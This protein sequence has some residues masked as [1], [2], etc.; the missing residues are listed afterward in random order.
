LL[1]FHD[2]IKADPG[3]FK[4]LRYQD[5][6]ITQ[7]DCPLDS[8]YADLW[9]QHNY[10]VY[11][12]E[13]MKIWHTSQGSYTLHEGDCVLVRKGAFIAEQ[14]FDPVFCLIAFFLPDEFIC[15]VLQS[16]QRPLV[17][18]NKAFA[19]VI[20]IQADD[21]VRSFFLSMMSYFSADKTPDPALL[22][23]KFRELVLTVAENTENAELLAYFCSLLHEPPALSLQ[24]TMEENFCFNLKLEAYARLSKRSLS[25][26]KRDF[27]ELYG[28]APGKWL[29]EKRLQ[30][31]RHLLVNLHKNVT[32]AAFESGFENVSHFSRAFR[33]YF[34]FSP[35][36]VKAQIVN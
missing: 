36:Q 27:Q 22:E 12:V 10:I 32:D 8:K 31:A 1:N 26:F 23:T 19:Q 15:S 20:P 21:S 33:A 13:G 5:A 9:S 2:T 28:M 17:Q 3:H 29:L 24:R 16:K 6:L 11:V 4:Q 34:G 25:A 7:Y 35:T 14:F 30:H 18:H